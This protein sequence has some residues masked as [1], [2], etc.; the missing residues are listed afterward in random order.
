MTRQTM[1]RIDAALEGSLGAEEFRALQEELRDDPAAFD[2]WCRQA[3]IHGRLEW[4]LAGAATTSLPAIQPAKKAPRWTQWAA[5]AAL[6]LAGLGLGL[7]MGRREPAYAIVS[8]PPALPVTGEAVGRLTAAD[9]AQWTGRAP[10]VGEWLNT[11]TLDLASGV[12]ELTF[13]CG[14]TV[15]L[16]GPARLHLTSPTRAMLE[17]GGATVDIPR[18]AYGFVFETPSTEISRRMSRFAVA[19]E[20]DGHAEIHVLNGQIQLAGKL[21]DLRTLDLAKDKA[22]RVSG[23][24]S[25]VADTRYQASQLAFSLPESADLL[26]EWYLHWGFDSA[27]TN[28]GT[29]A[30]TG[31]HPAF[32][33]P[34]TAQVHLA[35]AD[36]DIS[37]VPG[38]FGSAVRMNGQHGFLA[39][40]FPGI[41]GDRPRSVAFWVKIEPDTPDALAYSFL[42]WGI[43][44]PEG[45]G[46][47]QLGWNAGSD[48]PGTVGAIRT[49]VELGYHIGST[50]LRTG[51]WHHVA[52][53]FTG[54][55]KSDVASEVRHY[56]DGR[57]E[58]TTAVKS[59][60]VDTQVTGDKALPL[61]F[62]RRLDPDSSFRTFRGEMDEIYLFPCAL[63]PDQIERLFSENR[64]PALRR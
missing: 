33:K 58:A 60:R 41:E 43:K 5:A 27:D 56:I 23:D 35:H 51:R 48:N 59:H 47:W 12:A 32:D 63:T 20:K 19:V 28:A 37:L 53:V 9:A 2:H 34:F 24:G 1:E 36:A 13:D 40:S 55:E 64:P 45:G 8:N 26:P 31:R 44:N 17:S 10:Q 4:E 38:R 22:V 54:G 42:S 61:S 16:R 18:Q 11:G 25:V 62:G 52:S 7:W 46:M 6:V 29:F 39:T 14:A 15:Q 50:N 30:E 3:E 57:L 49:E 21:G